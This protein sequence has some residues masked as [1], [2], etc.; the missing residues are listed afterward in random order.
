M[1]RCGTLVQAGQIT[2]RRES[3]PRAA[4][5][6]GLRP[7]PR[8]AERRAPAGR[9]SPAPTVRRQY[10]KVRE[11]S[12]PAGGGASTGGSLAASG[13]EQMFHVKLIVRFCSMQK[14]PAPRC[15]RWV[16]CV[17]TGS[18]RR[19]PP[20]LS[21]RER[22]ARHCPAHRRDCLRL[23]QDPPHSRAPRRY[24][25]RSSAWGRHTAPL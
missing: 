18:L 25:Q 7:P 6:G 11:G 2:P 14:P 3:R 13:K 22:P 16:V 19:E 21:C 23:W 12:M 24:L 20:A 15:R 5:R 4:F 8:G 9:L 1:R 10:N 17:F